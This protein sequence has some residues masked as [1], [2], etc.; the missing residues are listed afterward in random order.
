MKFRSFFHPSLVVLS[1]QRGKKMKTKLFLTVLLI[2]GSLPVWA[3]QEPAALSLLLNNYST[4]RNNFAA[5]VIPDADLSRIVQAGIRSPSASNRQPWHFTV[6]QNL[7][8]AK[9]MVPDA[10]DGNVLIIVSAQG[11]AKTNNVQILDCALAIQSIYLAA[12]ALGYGSRIYTGPMD[13]LNK[14]LKAELSLPSGYSAV[15]LVRVGKV[16]GP[17]DAVSAAS[18]RKNASELVTYKK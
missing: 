2:A 9:K 18:A 7:A 17:V 6:V 14:N 13:N 8:L 3:Q 12:Q 10:A 15:G 11:D 16:Q 5:G 1:K 4:A